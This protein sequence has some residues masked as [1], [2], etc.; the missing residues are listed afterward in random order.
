MGMA[1]RNN[2]CSNHQTT[3]HFNVTHAHTVCLQPPHTRT[4]HIPS[5]VDIEVLPSLRCTSG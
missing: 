2:S 4:L 3:L 5:H 1:A